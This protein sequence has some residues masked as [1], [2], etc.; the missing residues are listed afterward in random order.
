MDAASWSVTPEKIR[1]VV[2]RLVATGSPRMIVLF[3]SAARGATHRDSDIDLLVVVADEVENTREEYVRLRGAVS[4]VFVPMD[5]L[6]VRESTLREL[7]DV[8]GLIYR[9][10]LR[11]G[12]TMYAAA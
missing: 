4:D 6:V 8:P 10:A 7:A 11:S 3:G 9:E 2:D 5:L 1:E 12:E